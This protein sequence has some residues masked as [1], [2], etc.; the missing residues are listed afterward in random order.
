MPLQGSD[1]DRVL[2]CGS[3]SR[4]AFRL[5]TGLPS[6]PPLSQRETPPPRPAPTTVFGKYRRNN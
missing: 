2:R 3:R 5:T 6:Y 1:E 4:L